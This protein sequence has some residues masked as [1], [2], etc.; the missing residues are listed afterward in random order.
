MFLSLDGTL[1]V[2]LVNFAI[3]FAI[4]NVV[5]LR[6]VGA[7]LRRRRAYIEG[8]Q[9]D[10]ERYRHQMEALHGEADAKRSAARRAAEEAVARARSQ[11][12]GEATATVVAAGDRA[13]AIADD[14]RRTVDAEVAT[15]RTREDELSH[16]LANALLARAAGIAR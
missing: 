10:Y 8:V 13:Q 9:S 6:P 14:A 2:Q 7:A 5:F 16:T 15:A 11:A 12:D 1:L 3:F 4:L